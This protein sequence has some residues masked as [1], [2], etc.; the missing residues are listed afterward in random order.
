LP[1]RQRAAVELVKLGELSIAEAAAQSGQTPGA[2]KVN[3]HRG[4][5]ALRRLL[6]GGS[7]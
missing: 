6:G 7:V 5:T 1:R 4:I 3:V 2:V